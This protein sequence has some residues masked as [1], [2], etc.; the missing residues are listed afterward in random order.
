MEAESHIIGTCDLKGTTQAPREA[1]EAVRE[2]LGD[3]HPRLWD[4]ELAASEMVTNSVV[5]SLS[6]N[7]ALVTVVLIDLGD[8]VRIEVI[9]AGSPPWPHVL[10]DE[11]AESG[12]GLFLVNEL[13]RGRWSH[14][15]DEAGRTVW[16]EIARGESW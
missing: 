7:G 4:I 1:R 15:A 6:S 9:D 5:H 2:I 3:A 8:A 10:R 14:Y 12:R 13:S 11:L 16:A